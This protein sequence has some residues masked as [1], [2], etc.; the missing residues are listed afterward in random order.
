MMEAVDTLF[1]LAGIGKNYKYP[2]TRRA[3][4]AKPARTKWT[5]N[6][7][8]QEEAADDE[9]RIEMDDEDASAAAGEA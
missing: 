8:Q 6:D 7:Q 1:E 2:E 5:P 3:D 9:E 4:L